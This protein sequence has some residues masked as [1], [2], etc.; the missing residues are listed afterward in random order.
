MPISAS[1]TDPKQLIYHIDHI[2]QNYLLEEIIV[3]AHVSLIGRPVVG[4]IEA[5]NQQSRRLP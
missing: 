2:E 1:A 4:S 5:S 3:E